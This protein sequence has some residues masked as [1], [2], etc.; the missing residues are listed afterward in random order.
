MDWAFPYPSFRMPVLARNCVAT[1]QP[2]AAQAGLAMLHRGGNAVDA[3]LATAIALTIVEPVNNG[4]GSDAFAI[5][6]DGEALVALNGSGRSPAGWTPDRFAGPEMPE[7]GWNAATIPGAVSAWVTL[8]ERYGALPFDALFEPAIRYAS[9][10]FLVSPVIAQIWEKQVSRLERQT[11]F[12]ETFLPHGRA[13]QAGEHFRPPHQAETLA[14]IAETRGESLYHGALGDALVKA[15]AADGGLLT[16]EDLAAHQSDWVTPIHVDFAGHRIRET[17]PNGQ[18]IA[19]LIALG[20]LERCDIAGLPPD[21][22]EMLHLQIEALKLGAR[23][24]ETHVADPDYMEVTP[25]DL[26]DPARLDDLARSVRGDSASTPTMEPLATSSTIYLAA[27]DAD[28]MMVSFIQSNYGGFGCGIV[29]P[30]TGIALNN[31]GACFVTTPGHPNRVGPKKRPFNTIIPGFITKDDAP[32][33]AFGVM[34]GS[35][36]PQGHLQ[37]ASRMLVSGQNPQTAI[38]AP[39]WRYGDGDVHM[40]DSMPVAARDGLAARGHRLAAI[41]PLDLGAAQIILRHGS[42]YIAASE[43]RRDGCAVGL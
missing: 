13:P 28:G 36:Q 31:R 11:G 40:E 9:D 16:A 3:A 30:G 17:P 39:R 38:D 23:D 14:E 24:A 5:I 34:G 43:S 33:A 12:A 25:D 2:L 26:L 7:E 22:P 35:M 4:L 32:V 20:I 6:W 37:V 21:S 18:G 19:A 41:S 29:V 1:T 10:G 8:S 27:A 15:S 42:G